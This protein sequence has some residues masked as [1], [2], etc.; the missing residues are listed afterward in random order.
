MSIGKRLREERKRLRYDQEE[1]SA[2]GGVGKQAQSKYENGK[3]M[4][5]VGYLQKI[6]EVGADIIFIV[7]GVKADGTI[8]PSPLEALEVVVDV[9]QELKLKFDGD[10]IKKLTGMTYKAQLSREQLKEVVRG[11]YKFYGENVEDHAQK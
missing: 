3:S 1:F 5:S 2:I 7:S 11:S 8:Y 9:Q 6:G 4:P 10:Q